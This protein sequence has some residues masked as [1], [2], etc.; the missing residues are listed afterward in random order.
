MICRSRL[1]VLAV[2]AGRA[3]TLNF[4]LGGRLAVIIVML[5]NSE[6]QL[7]RRSNM[8]KRYSEERL[9]R[10]RRMRKARRL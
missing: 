6:Q 9:F 8:G 1:L 5:D 7:M 2:V 10:I 4:G 3:T